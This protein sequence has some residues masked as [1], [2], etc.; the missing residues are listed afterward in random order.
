MIIHLSPA[1]S[2]KDK[3][4]KGSKDVFFLL[5]LQHSIIKGHSWPKSSDLTEA[6][7]TLL[8]ISGDSLAGVLI[9]Q[10]RST[11][12]DWSQD[13]LDLD[14]LYVSTLQFSNSFLFLS[15]FHKET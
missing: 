11:G 4:R 7:S 6:L 2:F 10:K 1:T 15:S 12:G 5:A 9:I 13:P 3:D 8:V 14:F